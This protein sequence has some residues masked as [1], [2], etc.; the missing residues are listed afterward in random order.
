MNAQY[1]VVNRPDQCISTNGRKGVRIV[2]PIK[3]LKYTIPA[4]WTRFPGGNEHGSPS[5]K[6]EIEFPQ[7]IGALP[8]F[9]ASLESVFAEILEACK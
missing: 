4:E 6:I 8:E 5:A 2:K 9:R 1:E 3:I 7:V